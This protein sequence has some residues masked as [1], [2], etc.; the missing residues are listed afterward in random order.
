[1]TLL[2]GSLQLGLL[3]AVM[4]LGIY[5]SFRILNIPDLTTE[6]S[7]T[8]GLAVSCCFTLLGH[9]FLGIAAG[10]GAGALSGS[11]TGFLQTK[12]G[13]HPVLAGILTMSGLYSINMMVL[14]GAPNVSLIGKNTVFTIAAAAIPSLNK[15]MAKLFIALAAALSCTLFL[16]LFF[17]TRLGL[18][19]RAAGDNEDM[20]RASSINADC[21]RM[22]ALA[23]SNGLIALCGA[24]IAQYQSFGDIN[25]GSSM[26]VVGLASVIIGEVF[27]GR[28]SLNRGFLSVIL[29][30]VIYRYIIAAATRADWFPAY[31]LK[32]SSAFIVL[33]ALALPAI[34]KHIESHAIKQ[35]G[36]NHGS[37]A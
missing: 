22:I 28:H 9:P 34:K 27:L 23:L 6:G 20:V 8:L 3:Y 24:L 12:L 7:F 17:A 32:L 4:V 11:F 10:T 5:V 15:E 31:M 13:I 19:I 26:L 25:S 14:G 21:T 18:C 1:M 30:S 35:G 2:I 33:L 29:G 16:S 36:K 37:Y